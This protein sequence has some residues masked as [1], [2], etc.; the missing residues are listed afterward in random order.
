MKRLILASASPRRKQILDMLGLKFTVSP[1]QIEER[2][3]PGLQPKEQVEILSRKKAE[4]VALT[5]HNAIILA[6]DTMVVVG[7]EVFGKP[8]DEKDAKRM[9]K[10]FSGGNH[11]I[12]TAFTVLDTDTGKQITK[13]TETKIWFRKLT[14]KEITTF[15]K[16]EMP[17]DKAGGYAIHEL[18]AIFIE[19]IEGDYMGAI[20]LSVFQLVNELKNFKIEVL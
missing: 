6:A 12:L 2:L 9:L 10:K 4:A 5:F 15:V 7:D 18:A 20:G 8:K 16:K 17:F 14:D 19:K 3:T 11:S 13:S 1:S